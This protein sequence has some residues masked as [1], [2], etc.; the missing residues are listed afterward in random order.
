MIAPLVLPIV[1]EEVPLI[2]LP[3]LM[4]P[5]LLAIIEMA[6]EEG[7]IA[8]GLLVIQA[9]VE[10]KPAIAELLMDKVVG[11]QQARL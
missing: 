6:N 3:M 4:L 2:D 5:A 7:P 8:V 1:V 9:M 10:V 11:E